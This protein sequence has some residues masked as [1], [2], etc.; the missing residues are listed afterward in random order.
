[1]YFTQHAVDRFRAR[2]A[3]GLTYAHALRELKFLSQSARRLKEHTASGEEKFEA[4][5]GSKLV[6]VVK[7]GHSGDGLTCVTVLYGDEEQDVD[8]G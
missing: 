6:F 1:M 4:S 7:R 3:P 5:D 8:P 2:C